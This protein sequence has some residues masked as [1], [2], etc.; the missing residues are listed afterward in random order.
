MCVTLVVKCSHC[1]EWFI[2]KENRGDFENYPYCGKGF[3][4]LTTEA[5]TGCKG[6]A[7]TVLRSASAEEKP[8]VA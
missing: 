8:I 3:E 4:Q 6:Y 5:A 2:K 1:G 7:R